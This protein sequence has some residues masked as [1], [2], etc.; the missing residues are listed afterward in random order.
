MQ[1]KAN[2][3]EY[4]ESNRQ[5]WDAW[6]GYHVKS[7]FYDVEG[8]KA[9]RITLQSIEREALGNVKDKS[10]LHLQCHF[11]LDTL[12][13][14]RLGARTTG[15][16]FSPEAIRVARELNQQLGIE[17][18][19]VL[20][21]IYDLP[22]ALA[23]EFDIVFT[24]YGVLSWLP[25]LKSWAQ[26][27]A[28]YLRPGGIFFV[29]EG[30]PFEAVFDN[31]SNVA[32]LQV[33]YPY[34]ANGPMR[35]DVQGSYADPTADS[36]G[37]EYGWQ[38]TMSDIVNSLI[39]AGLRIQEMQEYPFAAWQMFPFMEKHS[40]GWWYLPKQFQQIPLTFSLRATK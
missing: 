40:D 26:I 33:G 7:E 22:Q 4:M 19:F 36:H 3:N 23:G 17:A 29:V 21:N 16:D 27:V 28:R 10:L 2:M 20:S 14:A 30:H 37:V 31:A 11:G 15:V 39:A 24:S 38:H 8:F 5:L 35:F 6:T 9:G 25:D 13:W 1:E 34:F 12:S 32:S 18:N